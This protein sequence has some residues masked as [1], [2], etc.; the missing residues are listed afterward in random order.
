LADSVGRP[1]GRRYQRRPESIDAGTA[2]AGLALGLGELEAGDA[3]GLG[4]ASVGV[5]E[6]IRTARANTRARYLKVR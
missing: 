6:A 3:L 2:T 1:S 5:H 4:R